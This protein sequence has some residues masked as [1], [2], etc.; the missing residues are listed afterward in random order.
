MRAML[1]LAISLFVSL[2]SLPLSAADSHRFSA[3]DLFKACS[4]TLEKLDSSTTKPADAVDVPTCFMYLIGIGD[5]VGALPA[6][7]RKD[8]P[9]CIGPSTKA[10]DAAR[11]VV[12]T[13]IKFPVMR[14]KDLPAIVL[15]ATALRDKCLDGDS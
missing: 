8:S 13:G 12:A 2:T 15:V 9:V 6:P 3:D 11:L 4:R 5:T 14:D 7:I 10:E 1:L